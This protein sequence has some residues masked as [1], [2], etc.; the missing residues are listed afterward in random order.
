M[1]D[2]AV[3]VWR[4]SSRSSGT[5][6]CVEVGAFHRTIGVR[7]SKD[8]AGPILAVPPTSWRAFVA[9]VR[10]EHLTR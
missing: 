5:G 9:A 10:A 6:E 3:A 7:D 4:K 2:L 8:Q 1:T